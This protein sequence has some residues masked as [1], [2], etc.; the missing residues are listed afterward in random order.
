MG[1]YSGWKSCLLRYKYFQHLRETR[2]ADLIC[3]SVITAVPVL[4][5][6]HMSQVADSVTRPSSPSAYSGRLARRALESAERQRQCRCGSAAAQH[7]S[8]MR[9][10]CQ[11]QTTRGG[12]PRMRG[13]SACVCVGG[14]IQGALALPSKVNLIIDLADLSKSVC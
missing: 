3:L 7:G 8:G 14:G 1:H 13:P 12:W 4:P 10:G 6:G 5:H 2:R 11:R 9:G